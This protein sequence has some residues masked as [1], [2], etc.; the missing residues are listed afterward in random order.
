MLQ[1]YLNPSKLEV[2]IDEAGR[3]CLFGP[4]CVAAVIWPPEDPTPQLEIK[5][6]KQ[7]S[8]KVRNKLRE[9]IEDNAIAWSV[10]FL[11]HTDIDKMNILQAT[12]KGMHRCVDDIRK[13]MEIDTILVD[14]NTF[15]IYT[16]ENLDYINHECVIGGDKTYKSIA[17]ASILA[18]T[19]R[20]N[21]IYELV[22]QNPIL[23]R[24]G[25]HKNK[26]YGTK[27]HMDK[28][29]EH[30]PVDGHRLSFKPCNI[31]QSL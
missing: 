9:Y 25:L 5:D 21:Y 20:D 30:G 14:G 18:K 12:M 24:Y 23:E 7:C 3:G 16:D 13:Q 28:L 26:G 4:V 2:G 17:A 27:I 15:P 29:K 22:K 19:H 11:D 6:S 10:Q 8:E 31:T 1:Q